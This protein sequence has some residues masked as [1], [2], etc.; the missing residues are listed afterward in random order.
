MTMSNETTQDTPD[1]TAAVATLEEPPVTPTNGHVEEPTRV[2]AGQ[3]DV[4][5]AELE[6][7]EPEFTHADPALESAAEI[8]PRDPEAKKKAKKAEKK[9]LKAERKGKWTKAKTFANAFPMVDLIAEQV[10]T[11]IPKEL[12]H[13]VKSAEGKKKKII[14][15]TYPYP[16]RMKSEDY[17]SEVELL[18]IELVKMQAWVKEAGDR[19]VMLFE[20]RDAAGKGG[21]IK[22]FTENLNPRGARVVALTKPSESERGQWYFQRYTEMLP[23]AGE[24]VFFD[25]SWYNRA[26]VEHVMGF[27]SPHQYLEFMR[28]APEF[29][30]MLVRS[31]IRLF[32]FWFSVSRE[33][34]LRRFLDRA[35]DPLKQWKLSPMD[36]ES[37][38][39]WDAYTKA[40]ED[41]LFY[42]DTADAPWTIVRS[43]DKNRARLHA[44]RH[45]LHTIPYAGK[46]ESVVH[47][48]DSL[49]VGSARTIYEKGEK[50]QTA[51]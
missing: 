49:V 3:P 44:M 7:P 22:R 16:K 5:E 37:L 43:D 10:R 17:E 29:E 46:D 47:P 40:K 20:G 4:G 42:T 51:S 39:R 21:T 33:E 38:G 31:G 35:A 32:K 12:V 36:V 19:I 24:I 50:H 1:A 11:S 8:D 26:G 27:C 23:T 18:E 6:K 41:M 25:R 9:R 13:R 28:Q 48:P 2:F 15:S 30:R 45:I 34:Q 14:S